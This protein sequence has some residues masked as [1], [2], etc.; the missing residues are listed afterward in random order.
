MKKKKDLKVKKRLEFVNQI[1]KLRSKNNK[2]WMDLLKLA[3]RL[4]PTKT[5]K[6][7]SQIYKDDIRITKIAKKISKIK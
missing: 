6:I 1:Q 7:L 2:N 3:L 4:D 5:S